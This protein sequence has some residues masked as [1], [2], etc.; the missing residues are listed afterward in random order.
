MKTVTLSAI[1]PDSIRCTLD[2][3]KEGEIAAFPTDTVYGLGADAFS[4]GAILKLFE[5]KGRNFNKA[6]AVLVGNLE[7]S[8]LLTDFMPESAKTLITKFWPGGLTLI[9][10]KK[11]GLPT[12]LSPTPTIGIRM[13]NHPV[14]IELLERFGPLATTS[15]N[16]SGGK[17]PQ[18]AADVID[19]LGGRIPI[20]LDGG[21]CKGGVPSTIV[22]CTQEPVQIIRY[23][24][25]TESAIHAAL[26][27]NH[28]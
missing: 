9:V 3:L 12:S 15:A 17:N 19:Q 2:A 24:A 20:L 6:I 1:L 5:A 14:A 10:N 8:T 22:D 26:H 4:E 27:M 25:I 28:S 21:P 11:D 18:T 7:Q 16:L 23:G 13:P